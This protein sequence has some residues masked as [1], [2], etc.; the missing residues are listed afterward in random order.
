MLGGGAF[1]LTFAKAGVSY[2]MEYQNV[3]MHQDGTPLYRL[4]TGDDRGAR[5]ME[6]HVNG[7]KTRA[8]FIHGE[9][10]EDKVFTYYFRL[11]EGDKAP[12]ATAPKP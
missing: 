6:V 9:G 5:D 4:V 12:P 10:K 7:M 8:R 2:D 11:P 3:L 1:L